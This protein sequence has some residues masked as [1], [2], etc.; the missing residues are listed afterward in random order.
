MALNLHFRLQKKKEK[1]KKIMTGS[2]IQKKKKKK[3][4]N[5]IN[6]GSRGLEVCLKSI[7]A[8]PFKNSQPTYFSFLFTFLIKGRLS[9]VCFDDREISTSE[10]VICSLL[11]HH[12][13]TLNEL[14]C[15]TPAAI[16]RSVVY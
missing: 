2:A 16:R 9:F 12:I 15:L 13:L 1:K 4:K 5:T 8:E 11:S 14:I 7:A 6:G 3:K 10:I